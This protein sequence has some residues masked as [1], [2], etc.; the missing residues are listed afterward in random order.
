MVANGR[1]CTYGPKGKI[2]DV[3]SAAGR[4]S[5]HTLP[6]HTN[7]A[8]PFLAAARRNVCGGSSQTVRGGSFLEVEVTIGE[9]EACIQKS[10][11]QRYLLWAQ[12]NRISYSSL[13]VSNG[14]SSI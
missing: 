6:S 8:V 12:K 11:G 10:W 9:I 1:A 4:E 3:S 14:K 2:W 13:D 5:Y 7:S